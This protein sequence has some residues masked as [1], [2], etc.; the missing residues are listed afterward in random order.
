[1]QISPPQPVIA[2]LTFNPGR[3]LLLACLLT[4][5][6]GCATTPV[7]DTAQLDIATG[8]S[9][10]KVVAEP[11]GKL[12]QQVL[13]GGIILHSANLGNKT[14]IEVLAYPLNATQMPVT[15]ASATGRFIIES[16]DLLNTKVYAPGR[17]LSVLGEI[18]NIQPVRIGELDHAYPLLLSDQLHL[19]PRQSNRRRDNVQFGIGISIHN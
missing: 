16:S 3:L 9:P 11:T 7:F 8:L 14:Q 2:S 6:S 15:S 19:W 4:L 12:A 17:K 1:M 5:I 13:W 18:S 10:Q